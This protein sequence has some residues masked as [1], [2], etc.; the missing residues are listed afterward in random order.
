MDEGK[1]GHIITWSILAPRLMLLNVL[2]YAYN[3]STLLSSLFQPSI[4]V[5]ALDI[6]FICGWVCSITREEIKH[7]MVDLASGRGNYNGKETILFVLPRL[8]SVCC[9]NII[10]IWIAILYAIADILMFFGTLV[11]KEMSDLYQRGGISSK[12]EMYNFKVQVKWP[13]CMSLCYLSIILAGAHGQ[14]ILMW[15]ITVAN[16]LNMLICGLYSKDFVNNTS[17]I[18]LVTCPLLGIC[19]SICIAAL[20]GY[21]FEW[22]ILFICLA[23]VFVAWVMFNTS[24]PTKDTRASNTHRHRAIRGRYGKELW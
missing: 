13:L 3:A 23:F 20:S 2:Y 5:S 9:L 14:F 17:P 7:Y 21:L 12:V 4:I 24:D 16:V 8:I 19:S 10:D 1:P 11:G 6:L 18:D 15:V 22:R